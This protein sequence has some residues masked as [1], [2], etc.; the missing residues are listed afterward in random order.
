MVRGPSKRAGLRGEPRFDNLR[1]PIPPELGNLRELQTLLL[2]FDQLAGPI[3]PEL[4]NL[5]GKLH[6]LL[7]SNNQLT[8][9]LRCCVC[10][11][12]LKLMSGPRA[13]RPLSFVV[14]LDRHA[15]LCGHPH[16]RR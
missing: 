16:G 10:L 6:T 8:G 1:G 4:G 14:L 11:T 15:R 5:R 12:V 2:S 13:T 9:I 7:I 3:P